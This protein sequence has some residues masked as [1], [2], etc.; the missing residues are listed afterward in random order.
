MTCAEKMSDYNHLWDNRICMRLN[1]CNIIDM[2]AL[3]DITQHPFYT[4]ELNSGC[5]EI[6]FFNVL[7]FASKYNFISL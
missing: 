3:Y 7:T 1:K 4:L 5:V 6:A 2:H